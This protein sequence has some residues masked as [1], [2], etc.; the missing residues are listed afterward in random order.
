MN[1]EL[2]AVAIVCS[3][4][5][6]QKSAFHRDRNAIGD[7]EASESVDEGHRSFRCLA[8]NRRSAP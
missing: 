1:S 3:N 6:T 2:L 7:N 8:D 4:A 5:S